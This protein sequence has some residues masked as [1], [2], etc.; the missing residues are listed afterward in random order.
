V[1]PGEPP[2][3]WG[4][5]ALLA[6]AELL[7][8]A[9]WFA[10]SVAAA[11]LRRTWGLTGSET[12]WLTS[13]VQ[14]G[15]VAGTL[16]TAILNLADIVPSRWYFAGC[17][18]LAAGVN[19]ALL[20][21]GSF[22]VA[23]ASRFGT[24]CFLAGVYPPAM[25]MASTWFRS[26][27]GLAIGTVVGALTVGKAGPYLVAAA[28][29]LGLV[30]VILTTSA[31]ALVAALLV[32]AAYRDGPH[33]FPKRPFSWGLAVT[34]ARVRQMRLVT[35][36]YLGHMWELYCYWTW[37]GA[38][39]AASVAA[40]SATAAGGT[41]ASAPSS[42]LNLLAFLAIAIG[43]IGCVWGGLAADRYGRERVVTWALVA[44]GGCSLLVGFCYA[45][46]LWLLLPVVTLWGIAVVADSAQF[47]VLATEVVPAHAVGTALTLQTSLGFLLTLATIQLIPPVVER[48]GWRWAFSLL[49]LG[50]AFGI[51]C[52][53]RLRRIRVGEGRG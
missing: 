29:G 40:R 4:M 42:L 31:A 14:L 45:G 25:K 52:I 23:L 22:P 41:H 34:V 33:A 5:L 28:G 35:G 1:G 49:A 47:S 53:A 12:A 51:G 24:G 2:A 48:I 36:G 19:A 39:L 15:F 10:G 8:M 16:T 26:Q 7:G 44:S 43:G 30:P 21:A 17:A 11:E 9:L 3:R 18:A 6:V 50:P 20:G 46:S 32:A 13:A 27:R 37:I 38:Y